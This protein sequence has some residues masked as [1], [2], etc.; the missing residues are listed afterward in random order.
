MV[1]VQQVSMNS[2]QLDGGL[3]FLLMGVGVR[4]FFATERAWD[5]VRGPAIRVADNP[6]P[7]AAMKAY[8]R[9]TAQS[10]AAQHGLE[11]QGG[12]FERTAGR[13]L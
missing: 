6:M 12:M 11:V 7:A 2:L 5:R 3:S 1:R 4:A 8:K 9:K 10:A 13:Y